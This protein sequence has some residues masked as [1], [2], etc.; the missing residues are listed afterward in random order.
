[1]TGRGCGVAAWWHEV[2]CKGDWAGVHGVAV[3]GC[4]PL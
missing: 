4:R 3:C 1:M 2:L